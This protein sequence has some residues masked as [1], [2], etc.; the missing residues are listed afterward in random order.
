MHSLPPPSPLPHPH[1][2]LIGLFT[3]LRL[4]R[5]CCSENLGV[6]PTWFRQAT[7][8]QGS[9]PSAWKYLQP[10]LVDLK[11]RPVRQQQ[12]SESRRKQNSDWQRSGPPS[13][14]S[15]STVAPLQSAGELTRN[16]QNS[17]TKEI[18]AALRQSVVCLRQSEERREINTVLLEGV[19]V[20]NTVGSL[21]KLSDALWFGEW[22]WQMCFKI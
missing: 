4:P 20:D 1:Y 21:S 5:R 7:L 8:L 10:R 16:V 14:Q 12:D 15:S 18:D 11:E 6:S 17:P 22:C 19:S 3:T 13:R 9:R 2:D